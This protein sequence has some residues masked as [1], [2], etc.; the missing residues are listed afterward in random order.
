ME[1]GVV[2]AFAA[3]LLLCIVVFGEVLPALI[4]GLLLFGGY[5]LYKKYTVADICRMAVTGV[6]TIKDILVTFVLIGVITAVWRAS[7]TIPYIV[8][9]ATKVFT[10]QVMVLM[11][12]LLC[13]LISFLTGT[14][15][16][17]SAT[18]GVVCMTVCVGLGIPSSA[19]GGAVLAG[20]YFG[21]R[22]S[23]MSTSALLVASITKTELFRNIKTM[24]KTAAVPFALACAAYLLLGRA[25]A[26]QPTQTVADLFAEHF[27]LSHLTV[28]PAAAVLI[29]SLCRV[30]VKI[31]M[32]ASILLGVCLAVFVQ[33][34][35]LLDVVK[36]SIGGYV[37]QDAALA[38]L[39]SGGGVISMKN[40]LLIVCIS[41]CYVGIFKETGLLTPL[42]R[43]LVGLAEKTTSFLAVLVTSAVTAMV[44]CNQTLTIMLTHQLCDT[45]E[46]DS[47]RLAS[48]L[49]DT[50]VVIPP[51]IPWSVAATVT[52][53]SVGAPM[54]SIVFAFYLYLLPLWGAGVAFWKKQQHRAKR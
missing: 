40:V 50:T 12:F 8:Y 37:P 28:L 47:R 52:L 7:G 35:S 53:D 49:E 43:H 2:L 4:F 17:T 26:Q 24:L 41:S 51:L 31:T 21:D 13:C 23:P 22:C 30:D 46:G 1:I 42:K 11:T 18:V 34:M 27:V 48:Y 54:G 14:A 33:D 15:F 36:V 32:A 6:R 29:L 5:A 38:T 25:A 39:M 9:Y 3:S 16:G 20:S 10:P 45:V 44:T 19:A